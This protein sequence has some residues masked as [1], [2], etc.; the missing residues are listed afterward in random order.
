MKKQSNNAE[1]KMKLLKFLEEEFFFSRNCIMMD[2]VS[3][4]VAYTDTFLQPDRLEFNKKY[5]KKSY[6]LRIEGP[7][8][9]KD[10]LIHGSL[11]WIDSS[12]KY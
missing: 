4:K 8:L 3:A 11:T 7:R 2:F 1:L 12:G 9:I 5:E 10:T 6:K